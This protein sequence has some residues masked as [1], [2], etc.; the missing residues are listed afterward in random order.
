MKLAKRTI[1]IGTPL[2]PDSK[3]IILREHFGRIF[4]ADQA[5]REAV[6]AKEKL[7]LYED[8]S[9]P[10]FR[11]DR[12]VVAM[13]LDKTGVLLGAARNTN[14]EN[15]AHH[16]EI[17]LFLYLKSQRMASIPKGST[18]IS[19]LK[20]CRM[21]ASLLIQLCDDPKSIRVYSAED[22]AGRFGRHQLLNE[23]LQFPKLI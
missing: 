19:T 1:N 5:L 13:L 8:F 20:P 2:S 3:S 17:N 6:L 23:V 12:L 4:S 9:L 18:M 15:Q 7:A 22:D 10:K 16:A 21:C 11:R 14:A